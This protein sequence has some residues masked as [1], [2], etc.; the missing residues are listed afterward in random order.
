[1]GWTRSAL[2]ARVSK[3][4]EEHEGDELVEAVRHLGEQLDDGERAVLGSILLD[5]ARTRTPADA[6][7][8]YPRWQMFLPRRR[9][10]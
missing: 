4:A 10:R 1:M 3:F 7:G 2:E 6:T 9:R 5:R 8:D